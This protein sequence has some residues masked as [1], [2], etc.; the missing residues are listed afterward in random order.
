M[1]PAIDIDPMMAPAR[2]RSA[3]ARFPRLERRVTAAMAAAAPPPMPLKTATICGMAV[4]LTTRAQYQ[5]PSPPMAT[6]TKMKGK[7]ERPGLKNVARTAM[8]IAMP[9]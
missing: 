7:F 8:S 9:A 1:L 2:A 3:V 5:P 4:I 6:P